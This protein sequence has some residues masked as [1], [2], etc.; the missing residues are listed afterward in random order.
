MCHICMGSRILT[1]INIYIFVSSKV[2]N[3]LSSSPFLSSPFPCS[4]LLSLCSATSLILSSP[5]L[6]LF[7]F[8]LLFCSSL[9]PF[10]PLLFSFLHFFFLPSFFPPLFFSPSL[11]FSPLLSFSPSYPSLLPSLPSFL[12]LL[13]FAIRNSITLRWSRVHSPR[14]SCA[15]WARIYASTLNIADKTSASSFGLA[16][17]TS[18]IRAAS[19]GWSSLGTRICGR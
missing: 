12:L 16:S 4:S 13:P 10:F 18:R 7:L 14:V 17:A 15:T 1:Y 19:R 9:L 3:I 2:V 11:L 6:F 5:P 8:S